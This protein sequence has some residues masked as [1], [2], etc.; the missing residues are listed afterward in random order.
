VRDFYLALSDRYTVTSRS[1]G[2]TMVNSYAPADLTEGAELALD[3]TL[4]SLESFGTRFGSYP[5]TEL[6]IVTTS[7]SALGIEYPGVF[8]IALSLYDLDETVA[9]LPARVL[10]ESVAA[11]EAAHQWFYAVVGNDQ[12]DEPWLDEAL[13]Q[14]ATL[15]YYRDVRGPA[16]ARGLRQSFEAR[17]DRVD[18]ADIPI[19]LP[20]TEYSPKEYGAIVYGRGPLFFEA[21]SDEMGERAAADF[22][23]RYYDAHKW[24]L[25]DTES[26]R[27]MAEDHCNCD[28]A[29]L[30]DA[31]VYEK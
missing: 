10:L 1:F 17:W 24:G 6:D 5:Y 19:G 23:R 8:T 29:H 3:F 31:W 9:G 15:L 14:Y 25:A 2:E 30:F 18:R 27:Q 21:L 20:V 28:L 26:L 4:A 22:V 11:H 12:I 7:T 13:A 16:G